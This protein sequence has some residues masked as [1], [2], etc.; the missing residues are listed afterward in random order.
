MNKK[1]PKRQVFKE[2]Q[3]SKKISSKHRKKP[4]KQSILFPKAVE[5][6]SKPMFLDI[7][8]PS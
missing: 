4:N 8:K 6:A 7:P 5:T 3:Y 2:L 1:T